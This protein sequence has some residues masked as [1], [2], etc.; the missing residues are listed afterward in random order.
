MLGDG[1]E[2]L[3]DVLVSQVDGVLG[4]VEGLVVLQDLRLEGA[5]I[6]LHLRVIFRQL[7]QPLIIV[8][9]FLEEEVDVGSFLS[10]F[11]DQ[12]A[13]EVPIVSLGHLI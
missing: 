9:A 4:A 1:E 12:S 11:I 3:V 6:Q 2:V 10:L 7:S 13:L 5:P 8:L